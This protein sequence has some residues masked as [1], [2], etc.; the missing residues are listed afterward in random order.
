MSNFDP[1][2]VERVQ[3]FAPFKSAFGPG[4]GETVVVDEE[5]YDRLLL[6]YRAAKVYADNFAEI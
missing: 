1:E 6:L 4:G 3:C 5:D 2:K